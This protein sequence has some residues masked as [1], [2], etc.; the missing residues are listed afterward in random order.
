MG[1]RLYLFN[2]SAIVDAA[3]G[4]GL[5]RVIKALEAGGM[6]ARRDTDSEIR[7]TKKYRISGGGS[8]RLASRCIDSMPLQ[9]ALELNALE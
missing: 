9:T 5:S 7:K 2:K 3:H 4:H 1:K 6:L 8:A